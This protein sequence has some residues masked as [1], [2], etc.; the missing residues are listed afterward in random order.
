MYVYMYV[1]V[2][3]CMYMYVCICMYVYVCMYMYV[4]ICMYVCVCVSFCSRNT[5]EY[6]KKYRQNKIYNRAKYLK[7]L[8]TTTVF[9]IQKESSDP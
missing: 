5:K 2:Y 8:A 3:V 7:N 9:F 6:S 4:C 1:Y